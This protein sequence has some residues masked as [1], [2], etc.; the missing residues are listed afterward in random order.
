MTQTSLFGA[1][2]PPS[3]VM[4][5]CGLYR[6][7]LERHL[8]PDGPVVAV[9]MVNP[10]TATAD[11]D[12]HTVKKVIGFG[13]R[14]GWG[15]I[16]VG[17]LFSY[18]A[19]DIDDLKTVQDPAGPDNLS[20]IAAILDD[21]DLTVVA[22]GATRKMPE[23]LRQSWRPIADLMGQHGR[24]PQCWGVNADGHPKHPMILSYRLPLRDWNP[25]A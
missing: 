6:Y 20:H 18:R 12:D 22:W 8:R 15:R 17:N 2:P 11:E 25:P 9:V 16:I 24:V 5:P 4:S 3:A 10:S 19:T 14:L 23:S 7:R 13:R 21:A 1:L